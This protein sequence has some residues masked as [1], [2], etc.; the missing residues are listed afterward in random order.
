MIDSLGNV[1]YYLSDHLGSASVV[2]DTAGTVC[3]RF[4]YT[5]FGKGDG[6]HASL[7]TAY[8]YTGKPLDEEFGLNW[9]YYGARYYDPDMGRF[10]SVDPLASKYPG[11]GPYVYTLDNPLKYRDPDGKKTEI[12]SV[13]V[14]D[15]KRHTFIVVDNKN[16]GVTTRGYYP[17]SRVGA[18]GNKVGLGFNSESGREIVLKIDLPDELHQ[19]MQ[20]KLEGSS[21]ARLEAT[22]APPDGMSE[23]QFD[24]M[25]LDAA[26]S[27]DLI[28]YKYDVTGPNSN[29]MVDNVIESTGA[30]MPDI[31]G[32]TGQNFG[33]TKSDD[34]QKKKD[35][36]KGN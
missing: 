12:Y 36:T 32:A 9:Y 30:T 34:K 6:G 4:K 24:Q 3:D 7:A 2:M 26:E 17:K 11:W 14:V 20:Q 13:P 27:L 25:V 18:V 5:A 22:I 33:E 8:R 29:T 16:V 19:V 35:E 28:Q 31:P 23:E 15:D 21:R 1:Y 10:L